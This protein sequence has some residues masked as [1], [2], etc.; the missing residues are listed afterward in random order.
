MMPFEMMLRIKA[1]IETLFSSKGKEGKGGIQVYFKPQTMAQAI[2]NGA[3][4]Q[5]PTKGMAQYVINT[6]LDKKG[7]PLFE[8]SDID[9]VR[10][11]ATGPVLRALDRFNIDK[12]S[13]MLED[14]L[15]SEE[16]LGN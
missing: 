13:G 7:A 15:K 12:T 8:E 14:D 1:D 6:F 3:A 16:N 9:K 10:E 4:L 5:D 2:S 11:F